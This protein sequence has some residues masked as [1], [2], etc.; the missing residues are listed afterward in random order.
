M[1][2]VPRRSTIAPADL[3]L[4]FRSS[5]C[6]FASSVVAEATSTASS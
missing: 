1:I 3:R 4:Y 2:S 6:S 5:S